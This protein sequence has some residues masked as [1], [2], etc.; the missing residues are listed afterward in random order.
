MKIDGEGGKHFARL[1]YIVLQWNLGLRI[2]LVIFLS[3]LH[4]Y[5]LP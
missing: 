4:T 3:R 2:R 5:S 1:K